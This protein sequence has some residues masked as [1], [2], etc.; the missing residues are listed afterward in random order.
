MKLSTIALA[1]VA[2]FIAGS[3]KTDPPA[4]PYRVELPLEAALAPISGYDDNDNIQV[5]LHGALPNACYY[6]TESPIST[7]PERNA[8]FC[9]TIC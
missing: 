3:A 8:F 7:L 1:F 5:I 9:A 4:Q 6:V 2:V